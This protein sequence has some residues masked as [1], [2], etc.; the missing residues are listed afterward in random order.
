MSIQLK[1]Q[2]AGVIVFVED[3]VADRPSQDG[4]FRVADA[5]A[6][7]SGIWIHSERIIEAR[8]AH[9]GKSTYGLWQTIIGSDVWRGG[10]YDS[11]IFYTAP[12]SAE[13]VLLSIKNGRCHITAE[14]LGG[15]PAGISV[16][17]PLLITHEMLA[18]L[19]LPRQRLL[20]PAE[21]K[22]IRASQV[23][24]AGMLAAVYLGVI[25]GGGYLLDASLQA[26]ADARRS[27]ASQIRKEATAVQALMRAEEAK[28]SPI[29]ADVMATQR[30]ALSRLIELETTAGPLIAQRLR[31]NEGG[32]H[33][34]VVSGKPD[35]ISFPAQYVEVPYEERAVVTMFDGS[36]VPD[37]HPDDMDYSALMQYL[38]DVGYE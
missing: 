1:H 21:L 7:V 27:E 12:E 16:R 8:S 18:R 22:K 28:K 23:R 9:P 6:D 15:M 13:G 24:R 38:R 3:E 34:I 29:T 33:T 37:W 32:E 17:S 35:F 10:D 26:A 30:I 20:L 25:G 2:Q 19:P 5:S 31:P 4:S 36:D 11:V 14:I